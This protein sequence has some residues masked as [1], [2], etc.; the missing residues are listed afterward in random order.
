MCFKQ[1]DL[2][3]KGYVNAN[4]A[5][6]V[7]SKKIITDYMY[8]LGGRAISWVSKLQKIIVLSTTE[9]EYMVVIKA[10]K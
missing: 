2:G 3:L 5:R 8:T 9:V 6:D 10:S 1:L 7:D 4:M